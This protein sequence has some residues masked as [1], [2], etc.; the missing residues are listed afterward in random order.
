MSADQQ[1]EK[2]KL[3]LSEWN[4]IVRSS[5]KV[6]DLDNYGIEANDI[7]FNLDLELDFPTKNHNLKKVQEMTK[8]VLNGAFNLR[9]TDED[10]LD[11]AIKINE[12][13]KEK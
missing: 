9:L 10:C 5:K 8:E 6:S 11:A 7:Y 13:L 4:P 2:I 12:I 1:I 3:V